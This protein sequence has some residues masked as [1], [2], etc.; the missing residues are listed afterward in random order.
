MSWLKG[1]LC[2]SR[3][4]GTDMRR[5][6]V[7]ALLCEVRLHLINGSANERPG[8]V[9]HPCAFRAAPPLKIRSF[10]PYQFA[11][12]RLHGHLASWCG[13]ALVKDGIALVFDATATTK[14]ALFIALSEVLLKSPPRTHIKSEVNPQGLNISDRKRLLS[15]GYLTLA[16]NCYRNPRSSSSC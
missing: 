5:E 13:Y 4:L 2:G 3:V 16:R 7:V 11:T 10:G 6:L 8:R 9:E 12:H 15:V 1:F 14:A